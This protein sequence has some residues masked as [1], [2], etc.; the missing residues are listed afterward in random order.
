MIR[1]LFTRQYR[2]SKI[3]RLNSMEEEDSESTDFAKVI[4][5][6]VQIR[7]N[8]VQQLN[9]VFLDSQAGHKQCMEKTIETERKWALAQ[10]EGIL[11]KS[12]LQKDM[13][14][15]STNITAINSWLTKE[16]EIEKSVEEKR[17][18]VNIAKA[19]EKI[20]EEESNECKKNYLAAQ[21]RLEKIK[22]FGEEFDDR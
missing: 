16:K 11:S 12:N 22:I 10:Q 6:L 19:N 7:T 5:L 2:W 3:F 14:K 20:S 21:K 13:L 1:S 8:K 9:K 4:K 15:S 18:D 17:H